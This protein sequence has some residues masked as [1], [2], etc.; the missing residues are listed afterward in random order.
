MSFPLSAVCAGL[1][2]AT[3]RDLNQEL[4]D[5]LLVSTGVKRSKKRLVTTKEMGGKEEMGGKC[6]AYR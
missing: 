4:Q 3:V 1:T 5:M 6:T 2:V